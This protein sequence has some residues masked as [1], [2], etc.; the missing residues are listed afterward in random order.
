MYL[1]LYALLLRMLVIALHAK[2]QHDICMGIEKSL[3]NY[4]IDEIY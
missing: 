3:E 4:S 1:S 2:N